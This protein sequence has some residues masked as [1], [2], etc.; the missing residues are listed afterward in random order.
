MHLQ[1]NHSLIAALIQRIVVL[2]THRDAKNIRFIRV[3]AF[4]NAIETKWY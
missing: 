1:S 4:L 2:P 3:L